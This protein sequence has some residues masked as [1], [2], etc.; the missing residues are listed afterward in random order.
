MQVARQED[1]GL[2]VLWS[3]SLSPQSAPRC[4]KVALCMFGRGRVGVLVFFGRNGPPVAIACLEQEDLGFGVLGW[5]RKVIR[6]EKIVDGRVPL[7]ARS[8][9]IS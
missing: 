3:L 1:L 2:C 6:A 9:Y 8:G 5:E 7:P 4:K